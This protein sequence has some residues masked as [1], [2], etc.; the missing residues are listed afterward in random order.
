M[1]N[2]SKDENGATLIPKGDLIDTELDTLEA[3]LND[4]SS[5]NAPITID[6]KSV[7]TISSSAIG[8]LI[9]TQKKLK[10]NAASL[11]LIN[12]SPD[13]LAML[14]HMQLEQHITIE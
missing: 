4:L 13:N 3:Q 1:S 2:C 10:Q 14:K 9:M 6:M 11:S 8:L 7:T 5:G 12:L